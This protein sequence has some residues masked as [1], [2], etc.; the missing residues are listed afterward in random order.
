MGTPGDRAR[1]QR[2]VLSVWRRHHGEFEERWLT[3]FLSSPHLAELCAMPDVVVE[4]A[5]RTHKRLEDAAALARTLIAEEWEPPE[6]DD[7]ASPDEHVGRV[8]DW[9]SAGPAADQ[10]Q[11]KTEV[12][13][14]W[15][16]LT[17]RTMSPGQFQS[18]F[19]D[20]RVLSFVGTSRELALQAGEVVLARDGHLSL[21]SWREVARALDREQAQRRMAASA[22]LSMVLEGRNQRF[23]HHPQGPKKSGLGSTQNYE[24]DT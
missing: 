17:G 6:D 9:Q 23:D 16:D 4:E 5:L 10:I 19:K 3:A 14:L 11:S 13:R 7:V 20:K 2:F 21:R 22:S 18:W 1:R 8:R 12:L 24:D 15:Q